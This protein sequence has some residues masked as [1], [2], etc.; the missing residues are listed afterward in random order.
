MSFIAKINA[1]KV[2]LEN[3]QALQNFC[4]NKFNKRLTVLKV[5]RDRTEISLSDLPIV[6]ITRPQVNRTFAGYMPKI[7]QIIY[8]YA[9]FH[10]IDREKAIDNSIEFEELLEEAIN[11]K[12]QV[13]GD[14]P[15]AIMP[16]DS[17]NDEGMFHPVYFLVMHLTVKER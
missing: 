11:Q 8:L 10:Q 5:F 7:E 2:R 9:G 16:G 15:M 13:S 6:M 14:I 12:T 17:A 3:N 4:M 1:L